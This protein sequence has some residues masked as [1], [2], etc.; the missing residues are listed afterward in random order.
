VIWDADV[1]TDAIEI[2]VEQGWVTLK[3]EV[4]HQFQS[5]AAFDDVAGL[6]GV[7]GVSSHIKVRTP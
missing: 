5:G 3:G 6:Y 1:P 2:R 7:R 4:G